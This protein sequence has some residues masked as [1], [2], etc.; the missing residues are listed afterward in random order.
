MRGGPWEVRWVVIGRAT[1]TASEY[2]HMPRVCHNVSWVNHFQLSRICSIELRIYSI[3][4]C[5]FMWIMQLMTQNTW[6][7]SHHTHW[8]DRQRMPHIQ[9]STNVGRNTVPLLTLLLARWHHFKSLLFSHGPRPLGIGMGDAN[10]FYMD[11]YCMPRTGFITEGPLII[12]GCLELTECWDLPDHL[13]L[14]DPP[15]SPLVK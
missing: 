15:R 12:K 8:I 6:I 4:S 9:Y 14:Q 10:Q 11:I 2:V 13:Q 5:M 7:G 3:E 1:S